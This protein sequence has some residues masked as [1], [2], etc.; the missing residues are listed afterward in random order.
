MIYDLLGGHL[1]TAWCT[2]ENGHSVRFDSNEWP[3]ARKQRDT[4]CRYHMCSVSKQCFLQGLVTIQRC[5]INGVALSHYSGQ[6]PCVS[7][8]NA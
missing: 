5:D 7:V 6:L 1:T 2:N 8:S 4:R 3:S